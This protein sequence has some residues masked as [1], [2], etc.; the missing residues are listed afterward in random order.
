VLRRSLA[1]LVAVLVV[2]ALSVSTALAAD[3]RVR[4]EG[5]AT[6]IYGPAQPLHRGVSTPLEAL[7]AASAFGE[8]YY[9]VTRASVGQYVDRIGRHEATGTS[10]WAFKVNGVSPP[11]GADQVALKDGDVVLWYWAEFGSQGGPPTL[12]LQRRPRNCYQVL[13]VDDKGV[14]TP[15]P[16]AVLRVDGR[17]VS[18]NVSGRA[19]VGKHVGLV[20]ASRT[21][22]VI[23]N[24][25]R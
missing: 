12:E 18:T 7:E 17:R 10:G 23:S 11:V 15:E 14:R 19:C 16:G 22:A 25:V 2:T 9:H 6:T 24:A 1:S 3:V 4:V 21:G 20:R 13:S 5:R 8:F